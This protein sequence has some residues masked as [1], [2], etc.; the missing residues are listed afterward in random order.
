[1][2]T[3]YRS[4]DPDAPPLVEVGQTVSAGEV[5]CIIESMKI[6]TEI[7]TEQAGTVKSILMEN[8]DMVMKDQ[9]VIEIEI[10]SK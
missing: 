1:M 8:E 5:V 9:A 3:F 7:K 2:G 6:F 4:S 10:A